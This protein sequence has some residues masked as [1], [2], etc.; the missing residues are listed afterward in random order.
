MF[1]QETR[2]DGAG[3]AEKAPGIEPLK[4]KTPAGGRKG[5]QGDPDC[6]PDGAPDPIDDPPKHN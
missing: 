1:D 3:T 6:I 2:Q 5:R 4:S